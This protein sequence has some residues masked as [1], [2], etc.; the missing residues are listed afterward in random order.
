MGGFH[1]DDTG[2]GDSSSRQM[3][4]LEEELE[5]L[6][7]ANVRLSAMADRFSAGRKAKQ[8]VTWRKHG[9]NLVIL[10]LVLAI[11]LLMGVTLPLDWV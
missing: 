10:T 8:R 9:G 6:E 3:A 7:A 5:E 1:E 11:G 2:R 4:E